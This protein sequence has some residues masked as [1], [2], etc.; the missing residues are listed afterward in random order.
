MRSGLSKGAA[1]VFFAAVLS[2][3]GECYPDPQSSQDEWIASIGPGKRGAAEW[4]KILS[5][6]IF[7]LDRNVSLRPVSPDGS[8]R[9]V[10]EA[11]IGSKQ[12]CEVK[13]LDS[14]SGSWRV[15]GVFLA[16]SGANYDDYHTG[17]DWASPSVYWFGDHY[18]VGASG[19]SVNVYDIATGHL[20]ELCGSDFRTFYRLESAGADFV[21][22]VRAS[23]RKP[24][25]EGTAPDSLWEITISAKPDSILSA[26]CDEKAKGNSGVN[27]GKKKDSRKAV[28]PV[29]GASLPKSDAPSEQAEPAQAEPQDRKTDAPQEQKADAVKEE[30]A[31]QAASS[32]GKAS[33]GPSP[34]AEGGSDNKEPAKDSSN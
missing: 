9:C 15:T 28:L 14:R 19:G 5:S 21:K 4:K 16:Q 22:V 24:A 25:A 10:L 18:L 23:W 20:H 34:K 3:A 7:E 11:D 26:V 6:R 13:R 30:P 8:C 17:W 27:L 1:L 12:V 33:A 29:S 32:E 31:A 2:A